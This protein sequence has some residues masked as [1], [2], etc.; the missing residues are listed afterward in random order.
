MII[1]IIIIIIIIKMKI[2][3]KQWQNNKECQY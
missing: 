2:I 1:I 3:D